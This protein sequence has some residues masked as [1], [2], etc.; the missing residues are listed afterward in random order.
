MRNGK[1]EMR[2]EILQENEDFITVNK[3]AGMLSIPA[4]GSIKNEKSLFDLL[5]EKYGRI[6]IVHRLDKEASGLIIFAKNP[7][8]HKYLSRLF[9][10]RKITKKY[11]VLVNGIIER[12]NVEINKPIKQ[13]G[14]GR[15]GIAE[16]GKE[17]VTMFK[18]IK[19]YKDYTLL[20]VSTLTGRRHQIRV[21]LYS[22]GHPVTGD[23]IYGEIKE[24]AKYPPLMLH[25]WSVEFQDM[26][27]MKINVKAEPPEDFKNYR[28]VNLRG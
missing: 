21:H 4:R 22:I 5:T 19:R 27:W 1:R 13:F 8:A 12:E 6:Y 3:P 26:S 24:S 23:K 11:L 2:W 18:V 17:S 9:E 25:S 14:S 28:P 16:N 15:M 10:T 7:D 20:Q